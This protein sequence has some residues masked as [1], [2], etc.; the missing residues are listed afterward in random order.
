MPGEDF[1]RLL[2]FEYQ[3]RS[4][5]WLRREATLDFR[6]IRNGDKEVCLKCIWYAAVWDSEM[7][8]QAS[9]LRAF[10]DFQVRPHCDDVWRT[11]FLKTE[12]A[13]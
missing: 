1:T 3:F 10:L 9:Y 7:N 5:D 6:H 11:D 8:R 13:T 12:G 4:F 2:I